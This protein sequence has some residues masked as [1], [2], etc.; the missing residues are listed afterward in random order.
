MAVRWHLIVVLVCISLMTG[1]AECLSVCLVAI[2]MSCQ[3]QSTFI[4]SAHLQLYNLCLGCWDLYLLYVFCIL[5]LYWMCCLQISPLI[6]YVA[7][8]LWLFPSLWG[9]FSIW[10]SPNSI[11]AFVSLTSEAYL[12]RRSNDQCQR[13][14]CLYFLLFMVLTFR[15]F[16]HFEFIFY[17]YG[18]RK[19]SSFILLH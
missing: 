16:I 1:D 13:R 3:R 8:E 15:S 12:E 6:L 7:F 17:I 2:W 18:V 9:S 5:T 10:W 14:C 4:S 19:S 11:F